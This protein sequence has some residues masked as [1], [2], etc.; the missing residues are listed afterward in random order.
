MQLIHLEPI[1]VHLRDQWIIRRLRAAISL[2]HEFSQI[3]NPL[4]NGS[5]EFTEGLG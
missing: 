1:L 4:L 2:S 5:R 3:Q